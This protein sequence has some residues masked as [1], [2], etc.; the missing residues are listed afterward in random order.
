ML[1]SGGAPSS[2]PLRGARKIANHDCHRACPEGWAYLLAQPG[3]PMLYYGDEI[4][5]PGAGAPDHSSMPTGPY[6]DV[7]TKESVDLEPGFEV[8]ALGVRVLAR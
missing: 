8:P 4:G 6:E 2:P 5:M 1:A 3:L 7:F